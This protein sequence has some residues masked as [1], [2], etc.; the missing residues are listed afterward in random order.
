MLLLYAS[1]FW[2]AQNT[3]SARMLQQSHESSSVQDA[4]ASSLMLTSLHF[5]SLVT[6]RSGLKNLTY[7]AS[8]FFVYSDLKSKLQNRVSVR[9]LL[10][11]Y[12]GVVLFCWSF[13][14]H[15]IF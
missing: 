9:P 11:R 7:D 5:A 8:N 1:L 14:G 15:N 4:S 2:S 10:L 3:P 13:V 12:G 6:P